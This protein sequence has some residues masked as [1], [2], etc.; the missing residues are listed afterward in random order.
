MNLIPLSYLRGERYRKWLKRAFVMVLLIGV[1]GSLISILLPFRI[2]ALQEE[3]AR[4]KTDPIVEYSEQRDEMLK[5]LYEKEE[6]LKFLE[7]GRERLNVERQAY[8]EELEYIFSF[9]EAMLSLEQISYKG[10]GRGWEVVG[11]SKELELIKLY[12][13]SLLSIYGEEQLNFQIE[14]EGEVWHFSF[15]LVQEE[16]TSDETL[17]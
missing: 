16:G 14:K 3:V 1:I 5:G 8:F 12:K 11:S 13:E 7:E 2:Y 9:S 10:W 15:T 17:E 6:F 4:L